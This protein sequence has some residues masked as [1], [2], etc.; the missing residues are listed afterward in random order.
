MI[1]F[2]KKRVDGELLRMV[3]RFGLG[4][5]IMWFGLDKW[6]HEDAW[7]GWFPANIL[8]NLPFDIDIVVALVGACEF[9]LGVLLIANI[10]VR[11]VAAIAAVSLVAVSLFV[12]ANEVTV[13]DGALL[14]I[15]IAL[16][17]DANA[18]AKRPLSADTLSW[19]VGGFIAF[20]F[21]FGVLFLRSA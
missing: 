4:T 14:A 13:R 1:G 9:A 20:L 17:I 11:Y 3:L 16:T 6:I 21:L 5:P 8:P 15:A 19:I 2:F 12:G 7:Y 18:T 10:G